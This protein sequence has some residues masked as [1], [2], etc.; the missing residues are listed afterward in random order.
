MRSQQP[1]FTSG[2][3]LAVLLLA[4]P[5][6]AAAAAL[7]VELENFTSYFDIYP[8]EPHSV[9]GI[10]HGLD[11]AGE[12]TRYEL[13]AIEPGRYNLVLKCWT[14][15]GSPCVMEAEVVA[16][17]AGAQSS[18]F[19]FVGRGMCEECGVQPSYVTGNDILQIDGGPVAL[20]LH[21]VTG[22]VFQGDWLEFHSVTATSGTTWGAVKLL[23]Q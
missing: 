17:P 22:E 18:R 16:E 5:L 10:L 2:F 6:A 8:D 15:F 14:L 20:V 7:R 3:L 19:S 1:T 11:S 12:W 9:N 4:T 13:P 21:F 23:F